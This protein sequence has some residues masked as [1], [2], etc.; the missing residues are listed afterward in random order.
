MSSALYANAKAL[1]LAGSLDWLTDTYKVALVTTSG[2]GSYAVNLAADQYLSAIPGGAIVATSSALAGKA[3]T[4]GA[5]LA[6]TNTVFTA[7]SGGV[8]GALV[9]FKDTGVPSTSPL[10][11]Y[12]DTATGLPF[13]PTG[14]DLTIAWD[15]V[16]GVFTP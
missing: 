13:T 16:N 10:V 12:I 2:G 14:S 6:A 11:A 3:T 5:A 7:L 8:V 1:L 9:V 15:A 4:G